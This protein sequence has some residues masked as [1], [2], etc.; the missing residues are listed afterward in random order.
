[1]KQSAAG[2]ERRAWAPEMHPHD[3][4]HTAATWHYAMHRDLLRLQQW[5]GWANVSQVQVYAPLLP[6]AYADAARVW[7]GHSAASESK[8]V[9]R[10]RKAR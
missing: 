2:I 6:D 10:G 4:R 3:L 1:M 7:L 9:P 5:G 8:S